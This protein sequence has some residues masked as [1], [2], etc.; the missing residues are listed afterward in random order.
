MLDIG[1]DGDEIVFSFQK[2][3]VRFPRFPYDE[4]KKRLAKVR[5]LMRKYGIDALLLFAPENLYYYTGFKKENL[6]VGKRWRRS[7]T[8][9]QG[10]GYK[11]ASFWTGGWSSL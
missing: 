11:T 2:K 10:A 9:S 1:K 5:E 4:F 8:S 3:E 7:D 6:A